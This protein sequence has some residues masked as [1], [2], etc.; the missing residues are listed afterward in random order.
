MVG[1]AQGRRRGCRE[2][3]PGAAQER[4]GQGVQ[5]PGHGSRRCRGPS[6]GGEVAARE[7]QGGMHVR[8]ASG[9]DFAYFGHSFFFKGAEPDFFSFGEPDEKYT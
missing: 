1:C 2:W 5:H 3:P 7:P 6:R 8:N 9:R 4:T